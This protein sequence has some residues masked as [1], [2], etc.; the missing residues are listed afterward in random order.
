MNPGAF[1][2]LCLHFYIFFFWLNLPVF[3]YKNE[4][5]VSP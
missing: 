5:G 1:S 2:F 4:F 3:L